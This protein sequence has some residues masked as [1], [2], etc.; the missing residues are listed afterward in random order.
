MESFD[1]FFV[2][3]VEVLLSDVL[4]V[5]I[6]LCFEA[7]LALVERLLNRLHLVLLLAVFLFFL[8]LKVLAEIRIFL[9]LGANVD[10]R[11]ESKSTT[12][13]LVGARILCGRRSRC[14]ELIVHRGRVLVQS[15]GNALLSL[16]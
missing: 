1:Y 8:G 3:K 11:A 4:A 13:N 12:L 7:A 2:Q 15:R 10:H 16:L 9:R 14:L 5:R 6:L